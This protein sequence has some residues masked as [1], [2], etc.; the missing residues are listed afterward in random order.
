MYK[1]KINY[2]DLNSDFCG[3]TIKVLQSDLKHNRRILSNNNEIL[4]FVELTWMDLE[5]LV[6]NELRKVKLLINDR[7]GNSKRSRNREI[8]F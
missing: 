5:K 7:R 8:R 1:I 2:Y 6:E 4:K 3:A